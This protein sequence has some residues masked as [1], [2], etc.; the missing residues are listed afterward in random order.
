MLAVVAVVAL[1]AAIIVVAL[2]L[3]GATIAVLAEKDDAAA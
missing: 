1:P 3:I 2:A